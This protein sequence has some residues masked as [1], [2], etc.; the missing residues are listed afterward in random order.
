[1]LFW[2]SLPWPGS[3]PLESAS[4]VCW[5]QTRAECPPWTRGGKTFEGP[6]RWREHVASALWTPPRAVG[7]TE[8]E[9]AEEG[10]PGLRMLGLSL[11]GG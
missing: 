2:A 1:M 8:W 6:E 4:E 11:Q 5:L 3:G 10:N 9:G 7:C